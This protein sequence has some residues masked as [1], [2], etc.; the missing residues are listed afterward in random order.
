MADPAPLHRRYLWLT[1]V[2][3]FS[4]LGSYGFLFPFLGLFYDR[5]GLSG[6]Q[7]G[8][9]STLT[10]VITLVAAPLWGRW[11]D[12]TANPRRLLQVSLLLTGLAGLWLGR[13][14]RFLGIAWLITLHALASAGTTPL[15]DTLALGVVRRA[16]SGFGSVR[17]G[18]SLGWAVV[19]TLSGRLIEIWGLGLAFIS[20]AGGLGLSALT[21]SFFPPQ[22]AHRA[23]AKPA[24]PP[25]SLLQIFSGLRHNRLMVGLAAGLVL[26][27]TGSTALPLF[28]TIYL[29][30]LGAS[31]TL[32]GFSSAIPAIIE[33]GGML[34][35]DRLEKRYG[36][37]KLLRA[38]L[39]IDAVRYLLI[40]MAPMIFT[41][42]ALRVSDGI[43]FSLYSIAILSFINQNTPE[44]QSVTV[45]ALYT[46][47]LRNL[48]Q[49][50]SGPLSGLV[51]DA[52]GM[53]WLY[54]LVLLGNLLG[55]S[56]LKLTGNELS[57]SDA[58]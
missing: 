10:A 51:F 21:A 2:Y 35:A 54:A 26:A 28:E 45:L 23:H 30:R 55:W 58:R 50:I 46:V 24:E 41:I 31:E 39:L 16:N 7:I 17:L 12:S 53:I 43:R 4:L 20:Y 44:S 47:T 42:V 22:W 6:V 32:I 34:W 37:S 3:Y 5:Q 29:D 56:V 15:S 27:W 9:I 38:A 40:L 49:M 13:Q 25:V 8:L 19:T 36:A 57:V 11:G 14:T 1:R 48:V 18:G 52:F 33:L